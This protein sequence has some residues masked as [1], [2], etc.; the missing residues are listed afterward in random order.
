MKHYLKFLSITA[1]IELEKGVSPRYHDFVVF[2][3][4]FYSFVFTFIT[5][6]AL[7]RRGFTNAQIICEPTLRLTAFPSS[8]AEKH[9]ALLPFQISMSGSCHG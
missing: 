2:K 6:P 8:I 1:L 9:A 4:F 3:P 5:H 7:H